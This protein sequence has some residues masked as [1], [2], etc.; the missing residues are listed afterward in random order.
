MPADYV[1]D[2]VAEYA[3]DL[4]HLVRALDEA[5]VDVN[6]SARDGESVHF[7]A[8]YYEEV[9]VQVSSAGEAGDG[10]TENIDVSIQLR[11]LDDR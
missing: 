3:G 11:I 5:T 10:I 1:T 2:F 9:P 8:V 6:E 7:L 4:I